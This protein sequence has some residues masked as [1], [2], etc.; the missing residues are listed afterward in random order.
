MMVPMTFECKF[1][2]IYL[3][4]FFYKN[5]FMYKFLFFFLNSV[6]LQCNKIDHNLKPTYYKQIIIIITII[7]L[8]KNY[9]YCHII[10]PDLLPFFFPQE[11]NVISAC[12]CNPINK[13]MKITIK[14]VCSWL[15]SLLVAPVKK[16]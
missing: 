4:I 7:L 14:W 15:I 13:Q 2:P 11:N 3:F 1:V 5:N 9:L 16:L 6:V 8:D 10:I 12:K